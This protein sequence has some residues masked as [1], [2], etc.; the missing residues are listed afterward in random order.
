MP[1]ELVPILAA[2]RVDAGAA[3]TAVPTGLINRTYMV[4]NGGVR[5][6]LQRLNAIFKPELHLDMDAVTRHLQ[7]AGMM[8]PVL[9]PTASGQLWHTAADGAVWRMLTYVDGRTL[10][11]VASAPQARAAGRLVAR[12][13]SAVADLKHTF[14]FSRLAVHDTAAHL[15]AL[16]SAVEQHANH[17]DHAVIAPM[18]HEIL[19]QAADLPTLPDKPV[20]LVHGDLKISNLLFHPQHDQGVALVDLDTLANMTVAV[21]MGDALRSWCNPHGEDAAAAGVDA[22]IFAAA[23]QGYAEGGAREMLQP[24]EVEALVA[25]L[26]T[27]ALELAARFCTDALRESYFGWDPQRFPSRSAHNRARA[28]GQLAVSNAARR[29]RMQLEQ[30]VKQAFGA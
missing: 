26:Q 27:I 24:V 21:E 17:P 15:A 30:A 3:V 7:A 5:T 12:F 6:V 20:R 18:A 14:H 10:Q 19:T 13:H 16:A 22:A 4:D 23:V 29:Q 25:G 2:W 11:H 9:V 1:P 8:T 28:A